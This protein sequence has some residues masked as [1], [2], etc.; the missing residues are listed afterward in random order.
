MFDATARKGLF[1]GQTTPEFA[2]VVL[3]AVGLGLG[4]GL[5]LLRRR[6]SP[7]DGASYF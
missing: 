5:S 7:R 1:E 3:L 6:D 2:T 4:L